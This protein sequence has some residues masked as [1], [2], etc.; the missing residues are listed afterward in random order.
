MSLEQEIKD[1]ALELGFDA[2][3]ITDASPIGQEQIEHFEAWLRAGYAG[4]MDYMHR[5][6]EKRVNPAQLLD[7]AKAVIVVALGYKP[8]QSTADGGLGIADLLT[9]ND[10]LVGKVAQYAQYEDYHPFMKSLLAGLANLIRLQAGPSHRFKVCVDSAPLA[11]KALA[12]RAGLGFI[13]KNHLLIHP[14][15]GPQVLLGEIVT[16]LAL[17][18][19]E[20]GQGACAN[21]ERC[22]GACP[23]GALRADGFLNARKCISCLTQYGSENGPGQATGGWLFG[24][25]ECLLACPCSDSAPARANQHFKHYPE[26]ARLKLQE[27]LELAPDAFEARFPDSPIRRPGLEHLKCAARTCL[28]THKAYE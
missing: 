6:L 22:I 3:G 17:H 25:D 12:A 19:D 7:G 9:H 10:S 8:R 4:R 1:K 20:P 2:A 28:Q 21:C 14:R 26:R 16:T 18:P 27:L 15:L 11:E 5:N 23:T 24:C 13:G